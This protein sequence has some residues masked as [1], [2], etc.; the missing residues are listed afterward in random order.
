MVGGGRT[1][2]RESLTI[3]LGAPKTIHALQINLADHEL[4]SIAPEAPKGVDQ[5]HSW[6]GIMTDHQPAE[7]VLEISTDGNAWAAVSDTRGTGSD[8]PHALTVLDGPRRGR[9][10][11][12]TSGRLPFGGTFAVSGLRVFGRGDGSAPAPVLARAH[13]IDGRTARI[14]WEPCEEASGYNVRYGSDPDK[15]YHSWQVHGRNHLDLRSLNAGT[16]YWAAVDAFSENGIAA[17]HTVPVGL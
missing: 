15:L 12:I 5:G 7:L 14:E 9:Y 13:R 2:P 17:G 10:V 16:Y 4:G 3:D 1:R 11:R 6:R 8:R